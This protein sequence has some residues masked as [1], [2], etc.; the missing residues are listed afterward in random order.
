MRKDG[1]K[2]AVTQFSRVA[3]LS[4]SIPGCLSLVIINLPGLSLL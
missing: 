2:E 1:Q 3:S 4:S